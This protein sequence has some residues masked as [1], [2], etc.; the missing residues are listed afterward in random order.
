ML[1][2]RAIALSL[3]LSLLYLATPSPTRSQETDIN[4]LI[5]KEGVEHSQIM[6]TMHM[7]ADVYGP[8]LTGSSKS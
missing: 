5:R 2:R 7:L 8:R 6:K 4:S 1:N 3:I